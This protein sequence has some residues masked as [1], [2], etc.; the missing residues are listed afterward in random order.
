MHQR[1]AYGQL[2]TSRPARRDE[3]LAVLV[4]TQHEVVAT[5]QLLEIGYS[6]RAIGRRVAARLL[7]RVHHGVYTSRH[8]PLSFP[9]Q[10]MAAVLACGPDAV[11][12]H[13]AAAALH[14]LRPLPQAWIDVT[15]PGTRRHRGVRCHVSE[16]PEADR[17][18]ID[19]IPVT[20]LDRTLL[21]YAAQANARQLRSAVQDAERQ[22]KLNLLTLRPLLER[23]AG[24]RGAGRLARAL[25][26]LTDDPPW[27]I[28]ELEDQ[29]RELLDGSGIPM[30]E[31][32]V[33]VEG[34]L[35]DAVWRRQRLVVEV[36]SWQFHRTRAQ[37]EADRRRDARLQL[38]GWR[39]L[40]V[41]Y[42][43]MT[44]DR[45]ALLTE[46]RRLLAMALAA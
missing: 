11:I 37:F 44:G 20:T 15:A 40:R 3:R 13:H 16:L 19:A 42:R 43:R 6:T 39:V 2:D 46:I 9:G 27:T 32:N 8:T 12:S 4:G 36:D 35:V 26:E 17:T 28:S 22:Q 34:E 25:A 21:D 14:D 29:F 33:L 30:P 31:F 41:T 1:G 5:R 23:N 7:T 45:L 10:C 38:A 18:T 24:R